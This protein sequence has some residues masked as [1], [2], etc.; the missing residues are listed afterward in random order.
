MPGVVG[1]DSGPVG[2]FVTAAGGGE[3]LEGVVCVASPS[4]AYDVSL[5]LSCGLVPLQ[6]LSERVRGAVGSAAAATG[7]ELAS[8]SV[9]F[10]S[11]LVAG[12][13]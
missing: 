6:P 4:A 1:T 10:A 7:V 3:R 2:A 13:L 12:E 8:V 9:H 11:L 5:R